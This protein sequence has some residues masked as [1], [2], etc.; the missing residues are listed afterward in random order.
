MK[1]EEEDSCGNHYRVE[2]QV[3]CCDGISLAVGFNYHG[4]MQENVAVVRTL[5]LASA[6]TQGER[7]FFE[8]LVSQLDVFVKPT[9]KPTRKNGPGPK[10]VPIRPRERGPF[11][12]ATPM[13]PGACS[14]I[15]G[16]HV[17]P[18]WG[19]CACAKNHPEGVG[20]YN[21]IHR[22]VCKACGHPC[23]MPLKALKAARRKATQ[24]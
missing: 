5:L 8:S 22:D 1:S 15:D 6:K 11:A 16:P 4:T 12:K 14:Y 21:G 20:T 10:V 23:C 13:P 3:S 24:S 7:D 18:G 9:K 2:V 19:C 17:A